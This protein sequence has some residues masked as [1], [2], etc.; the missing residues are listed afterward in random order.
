MVRADR[1]R[2]VARAVVGVGKRDR[3]RVAARRQAFA[4][5]LT[6][7]V[8]VVP[9]PAASV[10]LVLERVSQLA[11]LVA[12]QFRFRAAHYWSGRRSGWP[13]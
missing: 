8:T 12:V 1:S 6:E 7:A 9:A 2:G 3:I 10:P 13:G 11:V 4:L 5:A